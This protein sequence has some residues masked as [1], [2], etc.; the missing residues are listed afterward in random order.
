[1][2]KIV[3]IITLFLLG[4]VFSFS[5]FFVFAGQAQEKEALKQ[6]SAELSV[7]EK[8]EEKN[9]L[10]EE[11]SK[12]LSLKREEYIEVRN[13]LKEAART[14]FLGFWR[15]EEEIQRLLKAKE[16]MAEV[17]KEY[18]GIRRE[19]SGLKSRLRQVER[20]KALQERRQ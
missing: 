5:N 12:E 19:I 10:L 6:D 7:Y 15:T 9:S 11:L 13:D 4:A 14:G 16:K 17:K 18:T 1:M 2:F 8:I 3:R 20:E